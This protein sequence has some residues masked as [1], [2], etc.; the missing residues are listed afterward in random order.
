MKYGYLLRDLVK[1]KREMRNILIDIAKKQDKIFY[2]ELVRKIRKILI[3]NIEAN[4]YDLAAMLGKISKAEDAAGRGMLSV[5][6][7]RKDTYRPGKGFFKLAKIL[8]RDV[9]DEENFWE[10]ERKKVYSSW[11]GP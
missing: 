8:G 4:S 1:L 7:V 5:I 6:V 2:S 9:S 10:N 11:S 3:I